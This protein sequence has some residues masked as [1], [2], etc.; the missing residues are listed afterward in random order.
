MTAATCIQRPI[1]EDRHSENEDKILGGQFL[2]ITSLL[3]HN[4]KIKENYG[5]LVE[6]IYEFLFNFDG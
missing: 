6:K 4:E 3:Q 5:F 1:L 2:L